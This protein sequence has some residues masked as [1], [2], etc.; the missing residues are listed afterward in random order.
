MN[1]E[2]V[3]ENEK[4]EVDPK[5]QEEIIQGLKR[6]IKKHEKEE[7]IVFGIA[8]FIVLI[9]LAIIFLAIILALF[10][11]PEIVWMFIRIAFTKIFGN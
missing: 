2:D 10:F 11:Y 6:S 9:P 8:A 1:K 7:K 4:K 5:I 3:E